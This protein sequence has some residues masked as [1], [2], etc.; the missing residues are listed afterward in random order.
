VPD[1]KN[2]ETIYKGW[3]GKFGISQGEKSEVEIKIILPEIKMIK[4]NYSSVLKY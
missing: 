2:S 3:E 4:E 1:P